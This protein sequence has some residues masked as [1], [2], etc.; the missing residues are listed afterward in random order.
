[1]PAQRGARRGICR[2][3]CAGVRGVR[4]R[5]GC[6]AAGSRRRD[7]VLELACSRRP[8]R[9]IDAGPGLGRA[10]PPLPRGLG[11]RAAMARR[12]CACRGPGGPLA[13][14]RRAAAHG[15]LD[16]RSLEVCRLRVTMLPSIARPVLAAWLERV[17]ALH[18]RDL[19]R[20]AAWVELPDAVDLELPDAG[21]EGPRQWVFPATRRSIDPK[22]GQRRCHHLHETVVPHAVRGAVLAAGLRE[23]VS[24]HSFRHSFAT[25]LPEDGSDIRTVQDLLGPA[26]VST[27][28]IDTHVLNR[29]PPGSAVPPPA[30]SGMGEG[31]MVIRQVCPRWALPGRVDARGGGPGG[32]RAGCADRGAALDRRGGCVTRCHAGLSHRTWASPCP[33]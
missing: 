20:G 2:V 12:P 31:A 8:G 6:G 22:T 26:D 29:G 5:C 30:C 9:G 32:S 24:R 19:A 27:T 11:S 18:T 16:M 33:R 3:L 25:Q 7:G 1:M 28:M 21:N 14:G 4:R 17:R 10:A 13:Y 23:R 15:D